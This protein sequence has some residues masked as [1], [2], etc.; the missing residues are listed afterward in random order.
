[1]NII[2]FYLLLSG[3]KGVMKACNQKKRDSS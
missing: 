1:M 2:M 3:I